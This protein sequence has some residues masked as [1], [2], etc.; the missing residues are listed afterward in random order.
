MLWRRSMAEA[1]HSG[2]EV[3]GGEYVF[4]GGNTSFS[5]VTV[6]R[7]KVPPPGSGW[8]FYQTV[9]IA[10][11]RFSRDDAMRAIQDLR[12]EF[13]ASGYDLMARNCNHFAEALCQKLCSSNCVETLSL[14]YPV[15]CICPVQTTWLSASRFWIKRQ[16]NR[17]NMIRTVCKKQRHTRTSGSQGIPS[18]VNRLAGLGNAMR[19]AVGGAPTSTGPAR[20]E[21]AGGPAAAG[22]V[23]R[24]TDGDLTS[25]VDWKLS[26]VTCAIMCHDVQCGSMWH[27]LALCFCC[28]IYYYM[29]WLYV[30]SC[31]R[32][33]HYSCSCCVFG[34]I[35][36]I[37]STAHG[38]AF[39][40]TLLT[41]A[42]RPTQGKLLVF[43]TQWKT[44]QL[45]LLRILGSLRRCLGKIWQTLGSM[46]KSVKV[47]DLDFWFTG[48]DFFKSI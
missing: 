41:R 9:E 28:I 1:Y 39:P 38:F 12:S 36:C 10:P 13:P 29:T 31:Q 14:E 40:P 4:G 37:L 5:G 33:D 8:T 46:D 18:W 43:W 7:P 32:S 15:L 24:T 25:E 22:L 2:V 42:T 34:C 17:L 23:A 6:Q 48:S 26:C 3:F 21:G 45:K 19:S 30:A 11:C 20:A 27:D 35:W 47:Q 16:W 44:I